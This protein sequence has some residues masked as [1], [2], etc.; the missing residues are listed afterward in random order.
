MT[1]N[2]IGLIIVGRC[3]G[4]WNSLGNIKVRFIWSINVVPSW[5]RWNDCQRL[6]DA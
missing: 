5:S 6:C 1:A 2:P 4:G 3:I